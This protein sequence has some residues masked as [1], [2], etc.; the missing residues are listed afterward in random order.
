MD[1][2]SR[3]FRDGGAAAQPG[4]VSRLLP[5]SLVLSLLCHANAV[6]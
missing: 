1:R 6:I 5:C 4:A 3:L 2:L